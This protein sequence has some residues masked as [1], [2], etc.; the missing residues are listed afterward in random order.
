MTVKV[1]PG[2][3]PAAGDPVAIDDEPRVDHADVGTKLEVFLN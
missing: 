2:R 3:D 1:D